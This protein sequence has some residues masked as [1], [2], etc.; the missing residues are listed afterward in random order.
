MKNKIKEFLIN[1]LMILDVMIILVCIGMFITKDYSETRM[2]LHLFILRCIVDTVKTIFNNR[3]DRRE[4][5]TDR[6]KYFAKI[7]NKR[8]FPFNY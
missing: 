4:D 5:L 8:I 6:Q 2:C 7:G 1:H 3:I